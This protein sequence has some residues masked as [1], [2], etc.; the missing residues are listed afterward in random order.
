MIVVPGVNELLQ[1]G[2]FGR[3]GASQFDDRL[4]LS[5]SG[6]LRQIAKADVALQFDLSFVRRF[7]AEDQG[8]QRGFACAIGADQ[9][10]AIL[11]IDLQ[12][13]VGKER[14]PAKTFAEAGNGQHIKPD[15]LLSNEVRCKN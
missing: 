12:G 14:S 1:F 13:G 9:S 11:P 6:F 4:V 3:D 8:Q 2:K 7:L 15:T 10:N 5:G